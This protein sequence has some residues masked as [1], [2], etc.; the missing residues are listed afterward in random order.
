M[1]ITVEFLIGSLF[2]FEYVANQYLGQM[3]LVIQMIQFFS[4]FDQHFQWLLILHIVNEN[5]SI[6]ILT[7]FLIKHIRSFIDRWSVLNDQLHFVIFVNCYQLLIFFFHH[8]LFESLVTIVF[9]LINE[10]VGEQT[11]AYIFSSQNEY[12]FS[13]PVKPEI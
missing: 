5:V 13:R 7:V 11:F 12:F 9:L 2:V 3:F 8:F 10:I 6:N 4:D 1:E